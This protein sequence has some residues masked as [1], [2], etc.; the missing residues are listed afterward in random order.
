MQQRFLCLWW[1][2]SSGV[3][4]GYASWYF[5]RHILRERRPTNHSRVVSR[6]T[7]L[8]R[9]TRPNQQINSFGLLSNDNFLV[10]RDRFGC[11]QL[12]LL[13]KD[14]W[15]FGAFELLYGPS[16]NNRNLDPHDLSIRCW[17]RTLLWLRAELGG[18][19][20]KIKLP[21]CLLHKSFLPDGHVLYERL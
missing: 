4:R 18:R 1:H 14:D 8:P 19:Q 5:D 11:V 3:P 10:P 2:L 17:E 7:W 9:S 12:L 16:R 21:S 20:S 15:L 6:R 13:P